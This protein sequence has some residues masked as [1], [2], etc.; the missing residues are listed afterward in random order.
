MLV[1][2]IVAIHGLKLAARAPDVNTRAAP[3]TC[4]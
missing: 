4:L 2:P 3:Y 1:L